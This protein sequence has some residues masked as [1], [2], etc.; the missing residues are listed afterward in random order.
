M[1]L[2]RLNALLGGVYISIIYSIQI[3][4]KTHKI[5]IVSYEDDKAEIYKSIISPVSSPVALIIL[6]TRG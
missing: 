5:T 2:A 1:K 6:T 3:V 4:M